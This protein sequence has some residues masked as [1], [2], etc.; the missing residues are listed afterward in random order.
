M[1]NAVSRPLAGGSRR[2]G[3][4]APGAGSPLQRRPVNRGPVSYLPAL[5]ED[6]VHPAP[7]D[8]SLRV[9]VIDDDPTWLGLIREWLARLRR[10]AFAVTCADSYASGLDGL[11]GGRFDACVVDYRLGRTGTGLDLLKAARR[12][13][14]EV[15]MLLLTAEGEGELDV[16]ALRSGAADFLEKEG[17]TAELTGRAVRY[18]IERSGALQALRESE[19]RYRSVF[20]HAPYGIARSCDNRLTTVNPAFVQMLGY[21]SAAALMAIDI[22]RD[23]FVDPDAFARTFAAD[24]QDGAIVSQEVEWRRE[25][26]R[27]VT[28]RLIVRQLSAPDERVRIHEALVEDVT[29]QRRLAAE[30][31]QAQKMEAVGRLAGGIAHDFNNL[32]T[33]ILGYTETLHRELPGGQARADLEEIQ[34]AA[35]RAADLTRQLL[36]FSR[37][38]VLT[39]VVCD[40]RVVINRACDL[41]GR[42]LGEDIHLRSAWTTEDPLWVRV[43]PGQLEQVLMNL[44]VNSRDAMPQG[45]R[46]SIQTGPYAGDA[47]QSVPVPAGPWASVRVVD[48]GCGMDARIKSHLFEPFFT[49][50]GLGKGTGLGLAMVYGIVKQSGGYIWVESEP[51][52]GAAFT[53]CLPIVAAPAQLHAAGLPPVPEKEGAER[54]LLVEDEPGVRKLACRVLRRCGYEVL[55]ASSGEDATRI[56]A[57]RSG[58]DI[59]LLLTDVVMPGMNGAELAHM[60]ATS[61]PEMRVLYMSGYAEDRLIEQTGLA[62]GVPFMPKPFTPDSLARKVREVLDHVAPAAF[63]AE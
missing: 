47:P 45:G 5:A 49:T 29:E 37:K 44:A 15:P 24:P 17:L 6:A 3:V 43:D 23:L 20:E 2:A 10:P 61:H 22:S 18:A 14:N 40:L 38:Q 11:L 26:G 58:A 33:A 57:Q 55:E 28:V 13:G 36:A 8:A 50:K 1:R 60:L 31:R 42:V 7:A 54:I 53:I 52:A 59:D 27:P 41:L 34:H 62:A 46:L 48:T 30:L 19:S 51:D 35:T 4:P 12:E 56:C 16:T 63:S 9:L 21:Q 39:P 32:L 25:D